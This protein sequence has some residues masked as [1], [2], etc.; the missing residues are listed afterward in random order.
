MTT[1]SL[2]LV[3][4]CLGGICCR[5]GNGALPLGERNGGLFLLVDAAS[6]TDSKSDA[7]CASED[8]CSPEAR[9]DAIA[10]RCDLRASHEM[11]GQFAYDWTDSNF[12]PDG[13]LLIGNYLSTC[14]PNLGIWGKGPL[15]DHFVRFYMSSAGSND[16]CAG[17]AKG[18]GYSIKAQFDCSKTDS[19][20]M[21]ELRLKVYDPDT[22][23]TGE[24]AFVFGALYYG[25]PL[26][27]SK[28]TWLNWCCPGESPWK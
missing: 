3:A 8:D 26:C 11:T 28:E 6:G 18:G 27:F 15:S 14:C 19:V 1:Q 12:G 22:D 21:N 13:Y 16:M 5:P 24:R 2:L 7:S 10:A 4:C 23:T 20:T 9:F 25:K 17:L